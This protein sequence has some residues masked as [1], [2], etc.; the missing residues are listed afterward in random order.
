M[1]GKPRWILILRNLWNNKPRTILVVLS[2]AV[3]VFAVGMVVNAYLL[4]VEGATV[5][6]QKTQPFSAFLV[7]SPFDDE[8]VESVRNMPAI[9]EAAARR[10]QRMRIQLG[11]EW[12]SLQLNAIPFDDQRIALLESTRGMFP[13]HDRQ[14][15]LGETVAALK[16]VTPGEIV[17]IETPD[18]DRFKMPVIGLVRDSNSNPSINSNM[19]NAYTTL[20]TFEWLGETSQYNN[21]L[22]IAAE[23]AT[24]LEHVQQVT[25]EVRKRLEGQGI[26]VLSSF[27]LPH[28]AENPINFVLDAIRIV[29]GTLALAALFL[30][31]FLVYNTISALLLSQIRE[32]GVM[33]SIG[34]TQRDLVRL[35]LALVFA[36]GLL[37]FL[38][39][40]PPA[41]LAADAF[42]R[43]VSSPRRIDIK[44]P[45]FHI[46]AGVILLE[47]CVSLLTPMLAALPAVLKG[48]R[49]SVREAI[50]S[51]GL[52]E[53]DDSLQRLNHLNARL[54]RLGTPFLLSFNSLFTH[55]KRLLLTLTTLIL[56]GAMFIGVTSVRASAM[57]TVA[58][59][60]EEYRFDVEV[61]FDRPY[62]VEE[63]SRI[64]ML[65]PGVVASEG[66]GQTSGVI[67]RDDGS[68]G[69]SMT[70]IAPPA[71]SA[72][73]RPK[74]ISGRWLL[75]EDQNGIV[76][77]T[78]LLREYPLKIGDTL[79]IKIKERAYE[80]QVIGVYQLTGVSVF[81][82]AYAN[83]PY[84][85][86]LAREVGQ[87]HRL[88]LLTSQ[89]DPHFQQQIAG[90]V[91][92][93]FREHGIRISSIDTSASLRGVT[94]NQFNIIV[95][96]LMIMALLMVLVGGLGLAGTMSMNV[97][98]R[99]REIGVMRAIGASDGII[100]FIVIVE[101]L[102]TALVS[103]VL[104]LAAALPV[105]KVLSWRVGKTIINNSLNF[106][107][108]LPGAAAWLA[109]V[110]L[111]AFA[112]SY[113]PARNAVRI[114]VR[115]ALAYE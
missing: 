82:T 6:Y 4:L 2:I 103:W 38:V 114:S 1:T 72:L 115:E 22:F 86:P 10:Q 5:N 28:P 25:G 57:Q 11:G 108:S 36:F 41:A 19:V 35:Y 92:N 104:A 15:L 80:W 88:R 52:G 83:Y 3:G 45:P 31:T 20:D 77:G 48:T 101:G 33:K 32:I 66:W 30:S 40:A 94:R 47:V 63:V 12:F 51:H 100:M 98:E 87:T 50:A 8:I 23:D 70:I 21:L 18:G 64:A 67:L 39:A 90:L 95:S 69:N 107:Y 34:A 54:L 44:L 43:F 109:L 78:N 59:M 81:Y 96:V 71:G 61:V 53:G 91:E 17:V 110:L 7:T 112:A 68:D 99:S 49:I 62:R 85:A 29:L 46:P 9:R 13:P 65:V 55:R 73:T 93:Q 106:V 75:P 27:I 76:V 26:I 111:I 102:L 84:V 89:H 37:A 16:H 74:I 113:M 60:E 105:G 97:M 56:G 24:N 42:A 79:R 58:D 14:L